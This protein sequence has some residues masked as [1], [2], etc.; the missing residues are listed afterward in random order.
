MNNQY[1]VCSK[2]DLIVSMTTIT[3]SLLPQLIVE[4]DIKFAL[5]VA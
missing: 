3:Q 5:E 2:D 1:K 4:I